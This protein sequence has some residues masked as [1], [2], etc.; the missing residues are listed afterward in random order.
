MKSEVRN[1]ELG[2]GEDFAVRGLN[3]EV[4][5]RLK[6]AVRLAGGNKVVAEKSGVP[7][8]T[9][10]SALAGRSEPRASAMAALARSVGRSL[11]WL[12]FGTQGTAGAGE[13]LPT[14]TA[15]KETPSVSGGLELSLLE[16]CIELI[17]EWLALNERTMTPERKANVVAQIYQFA[18]EDRQLGREPIDSHRVAQFLRLVA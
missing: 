14:R 9:L 4:V 5:A 6:E 1:S 12:F 3:P 13:Q 18:L 8:S 16:D 11:D 17:E 7:L 10:N 15:Q 2:Q